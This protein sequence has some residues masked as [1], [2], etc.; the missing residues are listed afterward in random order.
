MFLAPFSVKVCFCML[1]YFIPTKN[2]KK[3]TAAKNLTAP[4]Y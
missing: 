2:Y 4:E 1:R 3:F